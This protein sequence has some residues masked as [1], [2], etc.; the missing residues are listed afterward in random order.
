MECYIHVTVLAC[1]L[2]PNNSS[3]VQQNLKDSP[4]QPDLPTRGKK[5]RNVNYLFFLTSY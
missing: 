1:H 3:E 2:K 5:W 4:V